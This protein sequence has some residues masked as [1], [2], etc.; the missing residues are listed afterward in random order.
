MLESAF[1]VT[2]KNGVHARPATAL[3]LSAKEYNAEIRLE[4]NGE[5]VNLKSIMS[6]MSLDIPHGA[7]IKIVASGT[8]EDEAIKNV[9]ETL[10][11][12]GIAE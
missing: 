1:V 3:V 4:Y 9:E 6:V 10:K 8:D 12:K 11:T 2:S 5:K 7:Q